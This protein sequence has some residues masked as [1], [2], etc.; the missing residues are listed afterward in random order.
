[1][2]R[3][4]RA[5]EHRFP[6]KSGV[7]GTR[8]EIVAHILEHHAKGG[9]PYHVVDLEKWLDRLEPGLLRVPVGPAG[10]MVPVREGTIH[11][12]G[13][14]VFA[15]ARLGD[16]GPV[17]AELVAWLQRNGWVEAGGEAA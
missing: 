15:L 8:T 11:L 4:V 16:R 10:V 14:A 7:D 12:S 13:P 3:F 6:L 1:M 9:Y 5:D 17:R 2:P